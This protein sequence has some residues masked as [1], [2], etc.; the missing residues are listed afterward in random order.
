MGIK[1]CTAVLDLI[2]VFKRLVCQPVLNLLKRTRN[3]PPIK[4]RTF[5]LANGI[6]NR[7]VRRYVSK[8][9]I[10]KHKLFENVLRLLITKLYLEP[11]SARYHLRHPK[12]ICVTN[13][14][15]YLF[16]FSDLVTINLKNSECHE[17]LNCWELC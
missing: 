15:R 2:C 9:L 12:P 16:I 6:L 11:K 10:I 7:S 13:I 1:P 17:F 4:P 3:N 14:I 5:G 8:C